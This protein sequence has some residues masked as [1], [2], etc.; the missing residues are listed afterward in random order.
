VTGWPALLIWALT[1]GVLHARGRREHMLA[2]RA[3]HEVR[4]PLCTA[5]LAL[6][7][8][9]PSARVT[10]IGM[11]LR[12]AALAL[13]DLAGPP[14]RAA[15][16]LG[17]FAGP[18]RRVALALDDLVGPVRRGLGA[19]GGS[20]GPR[21]SPRGHR[22]ARDGRGRVD[23]LPA[24][25]DVARLLADAAPVWRALAEARGARLAVEPSPAVVAGDPLRLAQAFANLVTNAIEH[26]GGHVRVTSCTA[27][28]RV[29]IEVADDGPGL[30]APLAQ[31]IA[32][33][34]GRR[35]AR[36]HGLAIAAAIAERH[37][38]GLTA[39]PTA[40]GAR[41]ALELPA[42]RRAATTIARD[43]TPVP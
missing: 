1:A 8:L 39:T 40:R 38:G 6:D 31:L 28:G 18:H 16:A 21:L 35:S 19:R 36:G 32:A 3:R 14:R 26:G 34:R 24:G 13:D 20:L 33:A 5:Q 29:R 10:A 9:E 7:G 25:V 37:G 12:R 15:L 27:D 23:G 4:G 41:I 11:E 22:Y 42:A 30:P 2:A 43:F 17:C